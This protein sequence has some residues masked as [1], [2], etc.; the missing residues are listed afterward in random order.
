MVA[1]LAQ[2]QE[3][4]QL[5]VMSQAQPSLAVVMSHIGSHILTACAPLPGWLRLASGSRLFH[6]IVHQHLSLG[7]WYV[8][9]EPCTCARASPFGKPPLCASTVLRSSQQISE[10]SHN[11]TIVS[12]FAAPR[13][14]PNIRP[15]CIHTCHHQQIVV[16]S[17]SHPRQPCVSALVSLPTDLPSS[18]SLGLT[19]S[20]S[21]SAADA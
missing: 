8:R 18:Y 17:D 10:G 4:L 3:T 9:A 7:K 13:W 20:T 14:I 2:V 6:Q 21:P 16:W 19:L 5:V 1:T 15:L 11:L 12:G